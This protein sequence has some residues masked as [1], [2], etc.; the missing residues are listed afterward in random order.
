MNDK[1]WH[2]QH[3]TQSSVAAH[4]SQTVQ[5][6]GHQ[7]VTPSQVTLPLVGTAQLRSWAEQLLLPEQL[8]VPEAHWAV[9]VQADFKLVPG[10]TAASCTP[11]TRGAHAPPAADGPRMAARASSD[12]GAGL[13]AWAKPAAETTTRAT[14][15]IHAL[16]ITLSSCEKVILVL[17]A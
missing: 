14:A 10:R 12:R 7:V 9:A 17:L 15:A 1:P 8:T 16:F 3:A 13:G 11:S 5:T 6:L 4:W 2:W